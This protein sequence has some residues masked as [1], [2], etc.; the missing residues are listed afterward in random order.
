MKPSN[1]MNAKK[2]VMIFSGLIMAPLVIAL[3]IWVVP[4][5]IQ[6][7]QDARYMAG[8]QKINEARTPLT[9]AQVEQVMG[10]P[11]HVEQSESADQ[12]VTGTVYHYPAHGQDMNV[13]FV[14]GVVFGT[15]FVATTKS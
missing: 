2:Q 3:V 13:I 10:T 4:A 15:K 6:A 7:Y 1:P 14:N 5:V 9:I 8:F 12:T 11:T